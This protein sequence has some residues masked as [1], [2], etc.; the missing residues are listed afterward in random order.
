M[1]EL[2]MPGISGQDE[3][4]RATVFSELPPLTEHA[5]K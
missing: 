1:L 3:A 5:T 2:E 4:N